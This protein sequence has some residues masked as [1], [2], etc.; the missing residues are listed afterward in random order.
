MG[1][2][3]NTAGLGQMEQKYSGD[4]R[5]IFHIHLALRCWSLENK[6]EKYAVNIQVTPTAWHLK[7]WGTVVSCSMASG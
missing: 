7:I 3:K 5:L 2:L 6:S 1:G 4:E